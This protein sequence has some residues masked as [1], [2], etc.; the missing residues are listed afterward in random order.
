[1]NV[2]IEEFPQKKFIGKRLAMSLVN[3]RTVELWKS[4]MPLRK[5]ISNTIGTDL[6]SIQIFTDAFAYDNPHTVFEKWAAAAVTD[7]ETV[8]SEMETLVIPEGLYAVFH[9]Q[10]SSAH[11]DKVFD[12]IFKTWLPSTGYTIDS[13]PHFERLGKNYK[14]NDSSSEEEIW[15][16]LKRK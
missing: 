10:G 14:N 2:R 13:R 8:P 11:G 7:F 1:M 6:F 12:Y 5:M 15:I 3:N 16:P 4:F 9:Y